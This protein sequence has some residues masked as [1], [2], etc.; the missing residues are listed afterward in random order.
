[1]PQVRRPHEWR[2]AG[3]KRQFI[4]LQN[5]VTVADLRLALA[6]GFSDI[7]HAKRY[8]TLGIGTEQGR[9]SGLAG[10]AILAELKG[11]A[12][13][14][15]GTSRLRPPYYPVTMHALAGPRAGMALRVT[16]RTP[17]HDWHLDNGGVLETAGLFSFGKIDWTNLGL[18]FGFLSFV[19]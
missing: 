8:T 7:E 5:D 2:S 1:M 4:D 10:A 9:S 12:L 11:E 18:F 3:E 6:E 13:A 19:V 17:L 15:Q 16:R 14:T